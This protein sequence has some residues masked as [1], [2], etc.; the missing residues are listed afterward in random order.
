MQRILK[1]KEAVE[2]F[3]EELSSSPN[4]ADIVGYHRHQEGAQE[5]VIETRN[6]NILLKLAEVTIEHYAS[7]I[8]KPTRISGR[9]GNLI[10]KGSGKTP[11][12][13]DPD[14][15]ETSIKRQIEANIDQIWYTNLMTRPVQVWPSSL[16]EALC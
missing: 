10:Y 3:M 11:W 15:L 14:R 8:S 9:H 4:S 7:P 13:I 5:Y 1:E 12:V 16:G 2:S 6:G